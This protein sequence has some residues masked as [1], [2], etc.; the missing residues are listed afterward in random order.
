[1]NGSKSEDDLGIIS[2]EWIR[3]SSSLAIGTIVG[4]TDHEPVLIVNKFTKINCYYCLEEIS[5]HL[6]LFI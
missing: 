6:F 2:Y 4:K 1:M 5:N 3:D